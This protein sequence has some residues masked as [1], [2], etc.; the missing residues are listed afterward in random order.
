[1]VDELASCA[2]TATARTLTGEHGLRRRAGTEHRRWRRQRWL[3]VFSFAGASRRCGR[4]FALAWAMAG[5]GR[6][7]RQWRRRH[8][9]LSAVTHRRPKAGRLRDSSRNPWGWRRQRRVLRHDCGGGA[10]GVA[11]RGV[12]RRRWNRGRWRRRRHREHHLSRR[13]GNSRFRRERRSSPGRVA[14]CN[15][16]FT[17]SGAVSGAGGGSF[18]AAIGVGGSGGGGGDGGLVTANITGDI[19]EERSLERSRR[20]IHWRARW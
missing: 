14:A 3:R 8:S 18:G 13:C 4:Y 15:G 19:D 20:A 11:G 10:A 17:V 5:L 16:G 1:M 2:S 6:W 7:R 12:G 9:E